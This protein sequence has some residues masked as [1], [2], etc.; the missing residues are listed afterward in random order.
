MEEKLPQSEPREPARGGRA[1]PSCTECVPVAAIMGAL[2]LMAVP[3][4]EP[5]PERAGDLAAVQQ[6]E[7]TLAGFRDAR[8]AR[9]GDHG[10][11]PGYGPGGRGHRFHGETSAIHARA[12]LEGWS[13]VWGNSS[14]VWMRRYPFGPYLPDGIPANP[15]GGLDSLRMVA[16]GEE[17]PTDLDGTT[18]WI[19][20]PRTG[21]LRAS[22]FGVLPGIA[23][24]Y[25]DR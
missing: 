4:P 20:A 2:G 7:H 14:R 19:F 16:D 18:G 10:C 21:E 5:R 9:R 24:R 6:L 12:Q 3:R 25:H 17:L 13:D 8:L 15:L 23:V 1:N 22:S 11:F